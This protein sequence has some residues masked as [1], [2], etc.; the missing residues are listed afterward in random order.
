VNAYSD[1]VS[2]ALNF[3][4]QKFIVA[5]GLALQVLCNPAFADGK[6]RSKAGKTQLKSTIK[7]ETGPDTTAVPKSFE[8]DQTQKL[9][10]EPTQLG[11][12]EDASGSQYVDDA[13]SK[14]LREA[15]GKK[16]KE[17]D[18]LMGLLEAGR[19]M[20]AEAGD[21][22][23][24]QLKISGSLSLLETQIQRLK[25]EIDVLSGG[26]SSQADSN[27]A[28]GSAEATAG[29][30]AESSPNTVSSPTPSPAIEPASNPDADYTI[31][32]TGDSGGGFNAPGSKGSK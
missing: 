27:S 32:S 29:S 30:A 19:Q 22:R 26:I 23:S 17:I 11:S 4:A 10:F 14:V 2:V 16:Q 6:A 13:K 20:L 31:E 18:R 28:S 1:I 7:K 3:V 5:L 21:N 25:V 12:P 8:R 24:A 9:Q 15:I